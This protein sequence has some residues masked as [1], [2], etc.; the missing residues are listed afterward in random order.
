MKKNIFIL[1]IIT[2]CNII[3]AQVKVTDG[4]SSSPTPNSDAILELESINKNKGLLMPKVSLTATDNP[5]PL[6]SHIAGLTVYN[7]NLLNPTSSTGITPGFYYNDG[8]S[9]NKVAAQ[10]SDIGDIKYSSVSTDHDGW[11]LL[12]GRAVNTLSATAQ[13]NA[14]SLGF[15]TTLPNGTDRYLKSKTG[16]ETLGA[17]AGS[18]TVTLTQA[19]L[20]NTAYNVSTLSAGAHTHTYNDR[21]SGAVNSSESTVT[22]VVDDGSNT[23]T[24]SSA[25]AHTHTFSIPLGGSGTPLD[26]E[27]KNLS[28]YIYVYLGQ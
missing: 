21:A 20:P 8:I 5:S 12:N 19:N 24:T 15:T 13:A 14:A 25:G 27:P 10:Q 28:A 22:A 17:A 11:Y 9:W 3:R 7:T 16:T 26:L 4:V 23:S 18:T 2:L 1:I 6:P